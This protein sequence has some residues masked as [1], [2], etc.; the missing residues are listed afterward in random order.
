MLNGERYA[1][2]AAHLANLL[3]LPGA[4]ELIATDLPWIILAVAD[5]DGNMGFIS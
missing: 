2:I 4:Y 3:Q 5:L 1:P